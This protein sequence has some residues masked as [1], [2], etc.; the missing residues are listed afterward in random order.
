MADCNVPRPCSRRLGTKCSGARRRAGGLALAGW[1]GGA[2]LLPE[3]ENLLT[4]EMGKVGNP[5]ILPGVPAAPS[6][7]TARPSTLDTS[8]R[9]LPSSL[10]DSISSPTALSSPDF[11]LFS[12]IISLQQPAPARLPALRAAVLFV[13]VDF[14]W[15][16]LICWPGL[17]A[18]ASIA[19]LPDGTPVCLAAIAS[20]QHRP[21]GRVFRA[22]PKAQQQQL[23]RQ[24]RRRVFARS[25][26]L[27]SL[28]P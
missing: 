10:L 5:K 23:L 2:P 20:Q 9:L 22:S 7:W 1:T 28:T 21:R 14:V 6:L 12:F 13:S 15:S 3:A 25:F 16:R 4:R 18:S 8:S 17:G 24:T 19:H 11:A 27:R 26:F